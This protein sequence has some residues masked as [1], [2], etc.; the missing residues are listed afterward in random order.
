M[1]DV[2]EVKCATKENVSPDPPER[3]HFSNVLFDEPSTVGV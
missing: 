3:S 1:P 2:N